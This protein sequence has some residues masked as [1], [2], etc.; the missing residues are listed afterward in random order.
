MIYE[1][2]DVISIEKK[3]KKTAGKVSSPE[4][5]D[6]TILL[7]MPYEYPKSRTHV[8]LTS[9]EFTCLCPFSGLPDFAFLTIKYIPRRKLIEMKSLK[10]YIYSFR[11]VK[12]YNEHVVNKILL[13]LKKILNPYELSVEGEFTVRGGMKNRVFTEYKARK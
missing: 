5:I 12:I 3:A 10:H 13:D 8:E 11:N 7:S 9:D 6:S 2:R 1:D 4:D